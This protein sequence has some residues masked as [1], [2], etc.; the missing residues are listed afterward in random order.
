MKYTDKSMCDG[1]Q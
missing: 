1:M